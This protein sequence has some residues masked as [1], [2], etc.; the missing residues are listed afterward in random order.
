MEPGQ[1]TSST[2]PK[3][4]IP[5]SAEKKGNQSQSPATTTN[6]YVRRKVETDASKDTVT[7][8]QP[9]ASSSSI[10]P[11]PPEWEERYHHLQM[12]LNK[13]NDS[14]QTDHHLHSESPTTTLNKILSLFYKT[15][16][17][18]ALYVC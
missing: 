16:I 6:V 11:P 1:R 10:V 7:K 14:D 12:L 9:K 5:Q 2:P 15:V 17:L 18:N 3:E 8:Q 13:L 4:Q